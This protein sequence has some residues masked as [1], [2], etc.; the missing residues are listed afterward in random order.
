MLVA[1]PVLRGWQLTVSP[2][3]D[4]AR[5]ADEITREGRALIPHVDRTD[6]IGDLAGALRDWQEAGALREI[7][8]DGAPIGI[9]QIDPA[10]RLLDVNRLGRILLGCDPDRLEDQNVMELVYPEDLGA[11]FANRGDV[12]SGTADRSVFDGRLRRSDGTPLWCSIIVA[13]L[14]MDDG[15]VDTYILLLQ[16][17]SAVKL[18][19]EQAAA[20]QRELLPKGAPALPGY[21]LAGSCLPA[22]DVGGDLYDW[23]RAPEGYLDLTVADVMGKGMAA[24]LVMAR[25]QT[26]LETAPQELGPAQRVTVAD[27]AVTFQMDEESA[28]VTMFHAR[29]ELATG[30][31]RYVDA[32]HGYGLMVRRGGEVVRLAGASLPLGLALGEGF[33]EATVRMDPGDTVLVHSDGLVEVGDQT[34]DEAELIRDLEPGADAGEMVRRLMERVAASHT[35]D[36]TVVVLR[37][38]PEAG[39]D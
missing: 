35:D 37:R 33:V 18:Q 30:V 13:P 27:G 39:D 4:L 25:L 22:D 31:L 15:R 10:G 3:L 7:V 8:L 6:Q 32:G 14:R 29:L 5:T 34:V 24:A 20:F 1:V 9:V 11:A 23:T 16:D 21:D 2:L 38:L 36:V 12:L 26:A 28:F 19:A 17:V